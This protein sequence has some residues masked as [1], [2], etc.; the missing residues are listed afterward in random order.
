ME[1]NA[2]QDQFLW[3]KEEKLFKHVLVLNE[4]TLPYEEKDHGTFSQEYFSDYIMPVIPH[5]PWEFKNIPIPPGIRQKVI[6]FLKSKINAGVYEAS[7][8][9]Y[10]SR[11]FCILKKSGALRLIHDLQPLNKITIQDAGQIP[12]PTIS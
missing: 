4:Q 2:N 9:S 1:L 11:W 12:E 8:S 7:Q 6:E 10:C 3:S 5:T